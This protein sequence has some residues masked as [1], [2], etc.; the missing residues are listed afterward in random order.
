MQNLLSR[1]TEKARRMTEGELMFA[2]YDVSQTLPNYL[3]CD[4]SQG[5]AA[6]L[7]AEKDAYSVELQKRK[8]S[9]TTKKVI[10]KRR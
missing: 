1:Y 5:Y 3:D 9:R 10:D 4:P 2:L 7:Y 8:K 6:K